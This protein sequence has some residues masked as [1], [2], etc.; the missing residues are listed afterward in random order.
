MR[1]NMTIKF[2]KIAGKTITH[3]IGN[4]PRVLKSLQSFMDSFTKTLNT[5]MKQRQ[6]TIETEYVI[7][8]D[9]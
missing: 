9:G 6:L 7:V 3:K 5:F 2:V 4:D 1:A 8:S